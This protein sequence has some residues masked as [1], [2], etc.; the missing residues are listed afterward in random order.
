VAGH[1]AAILPHRAAYVATAWRSARSWIGVA[2]PGPLDAALDTL[3]A[4]FPALAENIARLAL[5]AEG[6]ASVYENTA[7]VDC[8]AFQ[9]HLAR[10]ERAFMDGLQALAYAQP[11]ATGHQLDLPQ[12]RKLEVAHG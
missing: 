8:S 12:L 5:V 3:R 2:Y 4:Q 9:A 6:E 1:S 11:A 10:W 7:N